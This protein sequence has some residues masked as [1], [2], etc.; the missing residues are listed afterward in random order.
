MIFP[1][2]RDNVN[3][4]LN[5][6]PGT[7]LPQL[8]TVSLTLEA[9]SP[10]EILTWAIENYS[11]SL[12]MATA[13][14]AEG[15]VLIDM[16]SKLDPSGKSVRLFNLETG[17]QFPETLALR[18][19]IQDKYNLTV[20]FISSKETVPEMEARLGGPIYNS[21]PTECC[22][23]R[24]LVPLTDAVVGYKAWISAI[25]RDQTA[26]RATADIVEWDN[27]FGLVKVNPL[28]NWTKQLV[29][30]YIFANDVPYNPLHD[31][32]FP[33]IGCFPC[34]RAAGQEGDD[35]SG[36]WAGTQKT[37]CGLHTK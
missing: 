12:T 30:E 8:K 33:S 32:G 9:K 23:L 2:L 19:R 16:L 21:N 6:N 35:R 26:S 1:D 4:S 11:P 14:G 18:E 3:E 27:K 25:R 36:R 20:E 31:Q 22:R 29:W 17:Y 24:K 37:E 10:Q 28:A 5:K 13:F 15:C 7:N 34:T